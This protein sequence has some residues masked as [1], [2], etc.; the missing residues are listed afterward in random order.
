MMPDVGKQTEC[1]ILSGKEVSQILRNEVKEDVK[2][3][4]ELYDV[5][6]GLAVIQVGAREDSNVYIRMKSRAAAE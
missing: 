5:T 4:Q 6:P 2:K 3:L 1:K